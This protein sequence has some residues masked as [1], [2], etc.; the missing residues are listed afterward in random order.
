MHGQQILEGTQILHI[1]LQLFRSSIA[2]F[3]T[4]FIHLFFHIGQRLCQFFRIKR[5]FRYRDRR[6]GFQ[7][8][9][10]L[11]DLCLCFLTHGHLIQ[12]TVYRCFYLSLRCPDL[13]CAQPIIFQCLLHGSF[14]CRIGFCLAVCAYRLI[15]CC[16]IDRVQCCFCRFQLSLYR[17]L[18]GTDFLRQLLHPGKSGTHAGQGLVQL[19][20]IFLQLFFR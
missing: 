4:D 20:S 16:P 1:L 19:R 5:N 14:D 13:I 6:N 10:R 18:I 2:H 15:Q 7:C 17:R 8:I 12:R 11:L 3:F 9:F